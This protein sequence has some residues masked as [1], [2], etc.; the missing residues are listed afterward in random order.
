MISNWEQ[1]KLKSNYHFDPTHKDEFQDVVYYLGHIEPTWTSELDEIVTK[2]RPATWATRGYKGE[3]VPPPRE[4]LA[5]EEYDLEKFGYGK[6]YTITHLNWTIPS[7]LQ[8]HI[9]EFGLAD[10][11]ARLHIQK[12]GELWNLHLDKL[13]KWAPN[14]PESVM[15]IFIQLTDWQPGQFWEFGNYHWNQWRAGDVVSFD[16]QNMPHCT[17]NAGM[18]NRMTLQI[19]G[20]KT[21]KTY[22]YLANLAL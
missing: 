6:D 13:G 11:M 17:A 10:C 9:D 5:S 1:S 22:E 18:H 12:P 3:G 20:V 16:W 21:E 15:R 14:N 19:T 4:D 7:V 2:S 8:K